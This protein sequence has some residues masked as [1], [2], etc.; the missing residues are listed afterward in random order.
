MATTRRKSPIYP[1]VLASSLLWGASTVHAQLCL[2]QNE[3]NSLPKVA[4]P[5]PAQ[6]AQEGNLSLLKLTDT[7]RSLAAPAFV[8]AQTKL[9]VEPDVHR[10]ATTKAATENI[11][12]AVDPSRAKMALIAA[13]AEPSPYAAP[14]ES[15]S[16]FFE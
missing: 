3:A 16:A 2:T 12:K 7:S 9:V 6:T 13:N 10:S 5:S 8:P 11:A 1:V 4:S 15:Q 14:S